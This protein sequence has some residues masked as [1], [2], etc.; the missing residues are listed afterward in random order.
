LVPRTATFSVVRARAHI[1]DRRS[2]A[3]G[4]R[5]VGVSGDH[6]RLFV[7]GSESSLVYFFGDE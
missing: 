1:C 4:D 2:P 7:K 6:S 5:A 3:A